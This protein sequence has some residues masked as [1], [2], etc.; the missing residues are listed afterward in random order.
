MEPQQDARQTA[1]LETSIESK[2]RRADI[3]L[4]HGID[5]SSWSSDF[6]GASL[7]CKQ[8]EQNYK[9]HTFWQN[10]FTILISRRISIFVWAFLGERVAGFARERRT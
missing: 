3:C 6:C 2:Q 10:N 9:S 8:K 7:W 5:T 1:Q 4:R